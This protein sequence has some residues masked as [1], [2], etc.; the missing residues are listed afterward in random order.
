MFNERRGNL[1][2]HVCTIYARNMLH[3]SF[4]TMPHHAKFA[5]TDQPLLSVIAERWSPRSF[6][7]Q[8]ISIDDI[9][10][11]L[12]AA[13]WSASSMNEQPWRYIIARKEDNSDYQKLLSCLVPFNAGWAHSAPV[14]ILSV[15]HERFMKNNES[16]ITAWHDV[17]LA[18]ATLA[19]QA[20]SMGIHTHWMGGFDRERAKEVCGIPY[21]YAPIAMMALGYPGSPDMLASP[22]KERETEPRTRKPI[23]EFAFTAQWGTAYPV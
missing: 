20:M 19:L 4:M 8:S 15:A 10:T 6:S 5:D 2:R 3:N 21:S 18:S 23:S 12:E 9:C 1:P 7:E 14:L 17:G 13:R 11:I 16:N 22:Y